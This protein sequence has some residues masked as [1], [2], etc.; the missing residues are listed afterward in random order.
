MGFGGPDLFIL[1]ASVDQVTC[2]WP[3]P[4][5]SFHSSNDLG[6]SVS[7]PALRNSESSNNKTLVAR[8]VTLCPTPSCFVATSCPCCTFSPMIS[9]Q[10]QCESKLSFEIPD[11]FLYVTCA[12][13]IYHKY[14]SSHGHFACLQNLF[15]LQHWCLEVLSFVGSAA[16]VSFE[17]CKL[18]SACGVSLHLSFRQ[19]QLYVLLL[20]VALQRFLHLKHDYVATSQQTHL[21]LY[22]KLSFCYFMISCVLILQCFL[23]TSNLSSYRPSLAMRRWNRLS[24]RKLFIPCNF[25]GADITSQNTSYQTAGG[26][27]KKFSTAEFSSDFVEPHGQQVESGECYHYVDHTDDIGLLNYPKDTYVFVGIPLE[28]LFTQ[29]T[30]SQARMIMKQ[31]GISFGATEGLTAIQS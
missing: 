6:H 8:W 25:T 24:Q 29:I 4:P 18:L 13:M 28:H 22:H 20:S 21:K 26:A 12:P 27:V 5:T 9:N 30:L 17:Q 31:H 19:V 23:F 15:I 11:S 14:S 7:V 10:S 3:L 1:I 16:F 2:L